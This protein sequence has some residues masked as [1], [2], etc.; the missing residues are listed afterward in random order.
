MQGPWSQERF[1]TL[2]TNWIIATNQPFSTV[3]DIE[4]QELL[5]YSMFTIQ[6]QISKFR[7]E[8]Q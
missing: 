4:F 5:M 6:Y 3:D 1:E 8:T 7:I 2:L